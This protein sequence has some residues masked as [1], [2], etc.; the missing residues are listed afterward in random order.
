V[1][2]ALALGLG[3]YES[4]VVRGGK[5]TVTGKRLDEGW[6]GTGVLV[7]ARDFVQG[8]VAVGAT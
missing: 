1:G 2:R 3:P 6:V 8:V 5:V 4:S 7:G